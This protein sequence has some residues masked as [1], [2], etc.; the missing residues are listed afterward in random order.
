[1]NE[2]C[3]K[4]GPVWSSQHC[5][6]MEPVKQV[7]SRGTNLQQAFNSAATAAPV[8]GPAVQV[9]LGTVDWLQYGGKPLTA[10]HAVQVARV[11]VR[12]NGRSCSAAYKSNF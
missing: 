4:K 12:Y 8:T 7:P 3:S 10:P 9:D 5:I 6:M 11:T 2:H 1:M